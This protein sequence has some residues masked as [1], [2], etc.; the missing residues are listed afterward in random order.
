VLT[1]FKIR[2]QFSLFLLLLTVHTFVVL[3]TTVIFSLMLVFA[4]WGLIP[5]TSGSWSCHEHITNLVTGVSQLL[6]LN[7]GMIFHPG[8]GG[9][10]SP[11]IP[12]DDLWTINIFLVTV[13]TIGAIQ[14]TASIYLS[15]T[16][17]HDALLLYELLL[18]CRAVMHGMVCCR[19]HPL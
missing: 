11:S 6:V 7:C 4:R 16:T 15:L 12:L 14:I 18:Q 8:F 10:D 5:T 17:W 19:C 3:L 1:E 9:L 13:S 2:R